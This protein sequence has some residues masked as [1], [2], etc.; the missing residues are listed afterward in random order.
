MAE[1]LEESVE[2][3]RR[4]R[5]R[6]RDFLADVSH[7]L[8]T[9][10]AALRT[11]NELLKDQAGDDPAARA[12]FLESSRASSSASTGSPRTCSSSR[13]S[14]PGW[15][16]STCDR[17]TCAPWSRRRS[18]RRRRR[19]RRRGVDLTARRCPTRRSAIRHDPQRIGQVVANLVGN[20]IK[21]TPRGGRVD[22]ERRADRRR[23]RIDVADTGVGIDA[24][25]AA[26]ASSSGSTAARGPTRRAA[27]AAGSGWRSSARSS[28]CTAARSPSTAGSGPAARS[29]CSCRATRASDTAHAGRAD[30]GAGR[31]RR[32]ARRRR[33]PRRVPVTGPPSRTAGLNAEGGGFFTV[34]R[35]PGLNAAARTLDARTP[36][37][38][39]RPMPDHP[40]I[41]SHVVS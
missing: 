13:S 16:C 22:V 32:W 40:S 26:R 5:D 17:T 3:I 23:R 21:F 15:C 31:G 4:D 24:G 9:P 37:S 8:R 18:S 39:H 28:T 33:P 6:S 11:F 35:R 20:A 2:I 12:E 19:P 7:E 29:R 1:R 30:G 36:T 34:T 41:R 14:T 10:I 25:R 27:A 38:A